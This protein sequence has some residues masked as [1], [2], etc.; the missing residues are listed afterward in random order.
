MIFISIQLNSDMRFK[1][2]KLTL[3]VLL[4]GTAMQAQDSSKKDF[5]LAG[6]PIINYNRTQGIQIGAMGAAYFKVNKEDTIS[7]SSS[8]GL[9]GLYTSE[10]S[11]MLFG[12][13]QLYLAKD[14]WRIRAAAGTLDINFQFYYD[15]PVIAVGDFVDYTTKANVLAFQLQ[16][17]I[18]RRVYAGILGNYVSA[19]TTFKFPSELGGDSST[20][21]TL[22]NI[23]Y[24]FTNDTR[25]NVNYPVRGMFLNFK[26]QFYR[27]W[28]GS[29]YDYTQ[30][31]IGYNQFFVLQ[32]NEKHV[33]VARANVDIATGNV[34]FEGQSV[35][36]MDDIRG[37]S[38]GEYRGNQIYTLQA[39][40]R[41]NFYKRFGMVGFFGLA[42]AVD[43]FNDIFSSQVLPGVGA[44]FRFRMIR[45]EKVNIGIDGAVGRN[46]YSITFRI[47]EAFA[48]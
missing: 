33:I 29:D 1:A 22:N 41:W 39:E 13:S 18:F 19:T 43:N 37:Y 26:N 45:S 4:A 44:G 6:I 36:G 27:D 2:L 8:A 24:I 46:D 16:R 40:Y 5:K 9:A 21:S 42:S 7:P 17:N 11:Y 25:D 47:G 20:T 14:K 3:L 31:I 48:R 23:G 15:V 35:V 32:K 30:F 28:V 38:Q 34:P 10:K 12:F